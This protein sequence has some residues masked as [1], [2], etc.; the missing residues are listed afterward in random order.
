MSWSP[1]TNFRLRIWNP[2]FVQNWQTPSEENNAADEILVAPERHLLT[3]A[4][5]YNAE[6][7]NAGFALQIFGLLF[8]AASVFASSSRMT[9]YWGRN[10]SLKWQ[11]WLC[12]GGASSLGYFG[13]SVVSLHTFGDAA[14]YRNHWVAYNFVKSQ[15]RWEGRQILKKAPMNY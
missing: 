15:N 4:Q 9:T 6:G 1:S 8:G 11:E 13:G 10:A 14:A 3:Q 2:T 12:L 5:L 7:G